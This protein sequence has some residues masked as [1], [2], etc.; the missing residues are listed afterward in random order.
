MSYM[1]KGKDN[2]LY[3]LGKDD[4]NIGCRL[5]YFNTNKN[6]TKS[7]LSGFG[8]QYVTCNKEHLREVFD[9]SNAIDDDRL[10]SHIITNLFHGNYW[11][12]YFKKIKDSILDWKNYFKNNIKGE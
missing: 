12:C 8:I 2:Y 11:G 9:I 6:K 4:N 10:C 5:C 3:K 1:L 7:A